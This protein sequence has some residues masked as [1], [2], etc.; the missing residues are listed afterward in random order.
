[1]K[2]LFVTASHVNDLAE[3]FE[4]ATYRQSNAVFKNNGDG[5]FEDVS[6]EAA[7]FPRAAHRG[8]AFADFDGDGRV[9]VVVSAIGG[10]AE[11]WR[12][13]SPTKN[14]W[15]GIR[16]IGTASNVDGIGARVQIGSQVL[17]AS[18]SSGYASSSL[19]PLHFGLGPA[20]DSTTRTDRLAERHPADRQAQG[21][22]PSHDRNRTG[23]VG[24]EDAGWCLG[25]AEPVGMSAD[26]HAS[27]IKHSPSQTHFGGPSRQPAR[28]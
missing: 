15:L 12:N 14:R 10:A 3:E 24:A 11:L 7:R 4:D 27:C 13:L 21:A 1:M 28:F 25:I 18:S 5:T 23:T 16:L 8:A 6:D 19:V 17:T 2:D 20:P 9:D 22:R 26:C